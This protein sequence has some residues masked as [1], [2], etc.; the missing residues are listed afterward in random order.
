MKKRI[1]VGISTVIVLMVAIG[2]FV[3]RGGSTEN[4]TTEIA[5]VRDIMQTVLAIG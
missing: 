3:R 1:I 5:A 2:G 4:V